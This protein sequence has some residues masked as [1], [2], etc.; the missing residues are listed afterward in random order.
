MQS[1]SFVNRSIPIITSSYFVLAYKSLCK[2]CARNDYLKW[3]SE[4]LE[5]VRKQERKQH[6]KKKY[7]LDSIKEEKENLEQK[8]SNAHSTGENISQ[9]SSDL[10]Y[11]SHLYEY[12]NS[13]FKSIN[14][15]EEAKQ[16]IQD[17]DDKELKELIE[18]LEENKFDIQFKR[19]VN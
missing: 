2:S 16:I 7:N 17:A 18:W 6:Y 1:Y 15:H 3:R 13:L 14:E 4:N 19:V 9:L 5:Q 10:S 8:M 11:Y 12:V